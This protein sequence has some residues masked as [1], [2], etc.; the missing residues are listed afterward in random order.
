MGAYLYVILAWGI[1]HTIPTAACS[2]G[3]LAEDVWERPQVF[4][5]QVSRLQVIDTDA[6]GITTTQVRLAHVQTL[7]GDPPP[8]EVVATRVG[9]PASSCYHDVQVGDMQVVLMYPD[10][11]STIALLPGR[12]DMI[13]LVEEQ[14]QGG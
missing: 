14:L 11:P 8:P 4:L 2:G 5:A 7:R 6:D 1:L 9:N 13:D 12:M 3:G 10:E